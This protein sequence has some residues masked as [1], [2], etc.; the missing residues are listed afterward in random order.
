MVVYTHD[1]QFKINSFQM[2]GE[3]EF[4][5]DGQA[6]FKTDEPLTNI[7][8]GQNHTINRLFQVLREV[9]KEFGSIKKIKVTEK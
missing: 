8:V 1:F 4:N 3:C 6:S 5:E 2:D 7:T 9:F